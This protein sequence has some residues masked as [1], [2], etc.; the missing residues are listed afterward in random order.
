M[1]FHFE[2]LNAL[3]AE[4][5]FPM[6]ELLI[7]VLSSL[8]IGKVTGVS[9]GKKAFESFQQENQELESE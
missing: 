8:G 3:V 5:T 7:S 4:D 1:G 9:D 6:R 2:N